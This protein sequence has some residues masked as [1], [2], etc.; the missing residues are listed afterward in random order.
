M[1]FLAVSLDEYAGRLTRTNFSFTKKQKKYWGKKR[2]K[3]MFM[4]Q[5]FLTFRITIFFL[6]G[7]GGGMYDKQMI[8]NLN[9]ENVIIQKEI[10]K[11]TWK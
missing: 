3:H 1:A 6:G 11:L 2:L 7:G 9:K 8:K 5:G 4:L 10:F